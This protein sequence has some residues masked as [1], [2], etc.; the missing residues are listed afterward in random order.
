MSKTKTKNLLEKLD[1]KIEEVKSS[2]E[3]KEM[4]KF[5]SKFHDYSYHNTILIQLQKPDASYVAGY[6]QWQKKFNRQVKKGEKGIAILAPF[7]YSKTV[8]EVEELE[9]DGEL[10]KE[11]VEK[12]V[13]RTHFKP[14]YVFD[15]NQTEPIDDNEDNEIPTLDISLK[16][17]GGSKLLKPLSE[18]A[19][20]QELSITYRN[21]PEGTEGYLKGDNIIIDDNLND[22]EKASILAHELGHALLGHED[23]NLSKEI[24]ELEAE[25]VAFVVMDHYGIEIKSDKYLALYKESYDLKESLKKIH[26]VATRMIEYCDRIS[27][28]NINAP[29]TMMEII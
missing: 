10:V 20:S 13:T 19:V 15:I 25:A 14:V 6:R 5:F 1:K 22:T 28:N 12:E 23:D 16:N 7:T 21:L 2:D 17:N 9:V 3:F 11:E 4:L 27:E 26:K 29:E 18:F 8:T 24:K